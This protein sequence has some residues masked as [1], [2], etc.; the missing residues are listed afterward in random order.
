[1][2]WVE[3]GDEPPGWYR[4]RVSEYFKDGSCTIIYDDSAKATISETINLQ[5]VEWLPCSRRAKRFVPLSCKPVTAKS[6]PK[7]SLKYFDPQN[8]LSKLMLMMLH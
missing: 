1:V 2:K 7:P 8:I 3:E 6:K 5:T 4:A